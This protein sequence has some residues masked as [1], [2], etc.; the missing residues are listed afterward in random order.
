MARAETVEELT[1]WLESETVEPYRD[2]Q[3]SKAFRQGGPLEWYNPP[4]GDDFYFPTIQD[5]R[6]RA[7]WMQE[8]SADWDKML[9]DIPYVTT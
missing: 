7:D 6:T 8:A 2:G 4:D 3:W 5:V 9:S 1:Q